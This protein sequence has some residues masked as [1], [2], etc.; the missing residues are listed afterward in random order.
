MKTNLKQESFKF[1]HQKSSILGIIIL[2]LLMTYSTLTSKITKTQIIFE[3]GAIQWIPI[4]LI[5][6]SSSFFFLEYQNNTI[7]LL[8]YKSSNKFK[9]YIS[10]FL[11]LWIYS[12]LLTIIATLYTFI[13]KYITIGNDYGWSMVVINNKS[14]L[15][16]TLSN[17]LG[18][19]IYALFIISLSFIL[20]ILTKVNAV[21]IATGLGLGFM[22]AG[23]SVALMKTFSSQISLIRWNPLNM[24]FITQQLANPPYSTVSKLNNI[25]IILGTLSYVVIFLFLGYQLFKRRNI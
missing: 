3:F 4:I 9:I 21:V 19:L 25:E 2:I 8:L 20:I 13:L 15:E 6:I 17:I 23:I 1:I 7:L 18:T 16:L 10:K 14:L 12:L 5:A 24:I 11:V 22:G